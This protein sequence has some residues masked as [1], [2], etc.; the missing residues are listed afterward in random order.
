VRLTLRTLLAYL[1]D[2]LQAGEIKVIGQKV[3]ESESARELVSRIKQVTRRRRLTVPP[4]T[5]PN[6]F[7][8]NDVAEY[9]DNEL[10]ADKVAELEKHC[11]ESDVHLA[12][13]AAC[14]KILALVLGEPALVPP[15]AK[16]RM[17]A[18]VQG[19]EAIPYRKAARAAAVPGDALDED[20]ALGGR[21]LSWALPVAGLLLVVALGLAV[22]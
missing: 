5:G 18:L 15:T 3:N 8:P 17:Y 4:A 20:E 16:E 1:D 10:D 7:D 13:I 11:L 6:G 21:W 19:R 9:L 14:H 12:E 22:Y 2:T